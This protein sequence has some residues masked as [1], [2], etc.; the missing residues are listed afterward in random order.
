MPISNADGLILP[1]NAALLSPRQ[2]AEPCEQTICPTSPGNLPPL[3]TDTHSFPTPALEFESGSGSGSGMDSLIPEPSSEPLPSATPSPD[4][5]YVTVISLNVSLEVY[6][7]TVEENLKAV[8]NEIARDSANVTGTLEYEESERQSS[9]TRQLDSEVR[10]VVVIHA[11]DADNTPDDIGTM[12][13]FDAL[14]M[15]NNTMWMMFERQ[16]VSLTLQHQRHS[17]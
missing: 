8:V 11:V 3:T 17:Y 13:L 14:S 15:T 1:R 2:A 12:R 4:A 7:E 16:Y 5:Y 6:V 9:G 10:T